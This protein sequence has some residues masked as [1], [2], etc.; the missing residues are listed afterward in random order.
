MDLPGSP[1]SLAERAQPEPRDPKEKKGPR[2]R[3]VTQGGME[4]GSLASPDP[5]GPQDLSSTCRSRTERW[6]ACR[7]L[8]A[9]RGTQAF[10]DRLGQREIWAPKASGAPRDPRARRASRARS[11]AP[12]AARW[13]LPRKEPR[14]SPASEDR[15]VHMD[16]RGTKGRLASLGGR[17]APG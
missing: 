2:E 5:P 15:R 16:G 10:L 4:W 11:S 1:A 3:K 14:E 7:D 8:R 12:M 9:G 6:Q 13:A 17:V